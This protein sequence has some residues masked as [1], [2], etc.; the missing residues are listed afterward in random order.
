[1]NTREEL[2]A[3]IDAHPDQADNYLVLADWLQQQQ[4]P[5]G[6]LIALHRTKE[7]AGR[8]HALIRELGPAPPRYGDWTWF[9]GFVS[10][11]R[12]IIDEDDEDEVRST[13]DHPSFR[14]LVTLSLSLGGRDYDERQ[15]LSG[16]IASQPRPCWRSLTINS[17]L[18]GGND[19]P[20]GD[21][22]ISALWDVLPRIQSVSITARYITPGAVR[23][24]TLTELDLNGEV[25]S[26]DLKGILAGGTPN[27]Q[28]LYLHD[29][30]PGALAEVLEAS[31]LLPLT[32]LG[33]PY[34]SGS[35]AQ[36]ILARYPCALFAERDTGDRYEQTGE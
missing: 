34:A 10:Y 31:P 19:P 15:W 16:A 18:R 4:D 17:Y 20:C 32:K 33:V 30:D 11:F 12:N 21:L 36:R 13:L 1:L 23:S 2:E 7:G 3:A 35:A 22:D 8:I 28:E 25:L 5:R 26:A 27:L 24:E 14:H 6:E 29:V 9:Y